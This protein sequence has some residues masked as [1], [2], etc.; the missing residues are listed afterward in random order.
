MNKNNTRKTN[1]RDKRSGIAVVSIAIALMFVLSVPF[2][3]TDNSDPDDAALGAFSTE[4]MVAAGGAHSLALKSDGTVWAWG[5]NAQR[6]LGDGTGTERS[7]PVQ[8]KGPGGTGY[9]TNVIAIAAGG[10]HSMALKEDGTVWAWGYDLYGQLGDGDSGGAD[11]STPIQVKGQD[12]TGYLTDVKAIAAGN[13]HSI[14]LKSDGTVWA[15]GW[16]QYGGLGDGTSG[17]P[18]NDKYTPVP[19]SGL[20]GVAAIAAGGYHSM[21]LKDDGTVWAWGNNAYGQLGDGTYANKSTPVQVLGLAG[22]KM[23]AS[24]RNHSMALNNDGKVWTWGYNYNGQLGDDTITIRNT[25][26]Q[27]KGQDGTGYLTDVTEITAAGNHSMALKE[28]GTVWAWGWNIYGQLGDGTGANKNTPVPVTG[29][30]DVKTIAAGGGLDSYSGHSMAVKNDGTV[31]A[32]GSNHYGQ[33]GDGTETGG[34]VPVHVVF[35]VSNSGSEG[36]DEG[37]DSTLIIVAVAAVAVVAIAGGAFFLMKKK[38]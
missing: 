1:G 10:N 37:G 14:A 19:V 13:M 21:A 28:D 36:G 27:V 12:G 24:G 8:V 17:S 25:P 29:L 26:V 11:K 35:P 20:T 5:W 30:T 33:I 34:T 16:N 23:I 4:P 7:T 22:V 2:V 6:Q 3:F 38:R 31:W 15:W 32:W 9:L 18:A